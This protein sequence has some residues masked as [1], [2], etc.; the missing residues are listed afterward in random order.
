MPLMKLSAEID[1]PTATPDQVMT[2]MLDPAFRKRVCD[3]TDAVDYTIDVEE[4]DDGTAKVVVNRVVPAEVPEFVRKMIGDTI[5]L[6][7][8]EQW[9]AAAADGTRTAD[10]LVAVKGQPARMSGTMG[11]VRSGGGVK[12]FVDGDVEV[13]IAFFGSRIEPE[14]AKGIL[15]AIAVEQQVG[16]AWLS[17]A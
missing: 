12:L 4:Y 8:T 14:L 15:A 11:L 5:S 17:G 6:T 9:S 3:A 7:Q 10:V 16:E 2:M 13:K 1:H